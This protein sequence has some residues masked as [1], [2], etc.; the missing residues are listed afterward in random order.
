MLIR[1]VVPT[2]VLELHALYF[3]LIQPL[4]PKIASLV[5]VLILVYYPPP[6]VP[7]IQ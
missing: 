1:R 3:S 6:Y 4:L 2:G 7:R 5:S